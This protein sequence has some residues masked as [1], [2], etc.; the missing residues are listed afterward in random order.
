M[1][2]ITTGKNKNYDIVL[3]MLKPTAFL[4]LGVLQFV[5]EGINI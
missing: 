1:E 5:L 4:G 2:P 3:K